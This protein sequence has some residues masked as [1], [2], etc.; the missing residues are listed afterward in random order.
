MRNY[1]N[2]HKKFYN[3]LNNMQQ[4]NTNCS[5]FKQKSKA[6]HIHPATEIICGYDTLPAP[7]AR[8]TLRKW[9][10]ET[11]AALISKHP[12]AEPT[13]ILRPNKENACW[14]RHSGQR[15]LRPFG[16]PLPFENSTINLEHPGHLRRNKFEINERTTCAVHVYAKIHDTS[17]L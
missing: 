8:K 14:K 15:L 10:C 12:S 3:V 2:I 4:R 1:Q 17:K 5:I 9:G 7:R 13:S 11:N 16:K 6:R